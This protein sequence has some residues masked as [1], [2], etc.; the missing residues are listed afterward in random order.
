MS[1]ESIPLTNS[2]VKYSNIKKLYEF[3]LLLLELSNLSDLDFIYNNQE[4][5]DHVYNIINDALSLYFHN[6][7]EEGFLIVR[8]YC[9]L[10]VAQLLIVNIINHP[11]RISYNESHPG[12]LRKLINEFTLELKHVLIQFKLFKTYGKNIPSIWKREI[13]K[14]LENIS[15]DNIIKYINNT[16]N[17]NEFKKIYNVN[18]VDIIRIV[19]P[20]GKENS[21]IKKLL[22]HESLNYEIKINHKDY[23]KN[24]YFE[25]KEYTGKDL[26]IN[27]Y[28]IIKSILENNKNNVKIS[29]DE[30]YS[31]L[32]L[33]MKLGYYTLYS[34]Y[35]ALRCLQKK[36]NDLIIRDN[37]IN[38]NSI[39]FNWL[40]EGIE[41][42]YSK[43]EKIKGR[44]DCL[45][46]N[47]EY[48]Y[49]NYESEYGTISVV[50]LNN[51]SALVTT[52]TAND[53]Y[54]WIF[55]DN[56]VNIPVNRNL[57]ILENLLE[58]TRIGI[59]MKGHT[60]NGLS[61]FWEKNN[62]SE[63]NTVFIYSDINTANYKLEL[64]LSEKYIQD[65]NS[66]I[67]LIK[68]SSDNQTILPNFID[69]IISF[70]G[71]SSNESKF[72]NDIMEFIGINI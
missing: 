3:N 33:N 30:L 9:N 54:I 56:L 6:T 51:L 22:K 17:I 62:K 55:S 36:C 43:M 67:I 29:L 35:I 20:K 5:N 2:L 50:E 14:I 58:L 70:T 38:I 37:D 45:S 18:I 23:E 11:N 27:L 39:I 59:N 41:I 57:T 72:A 13:A 48:S 52:M 60:K 34:Y 25:N 44:V 71:P 46:D 28:S 63:F 19:H 24:F 15:E 32:L 40:S 8:R 68:I 1:S 4:N 49:T 47:S 7:I 69:N 42:E 65:I 64:E 66:I 26:L 21:I 10:H 16:N 12:I 31:K 53:G 61:Q